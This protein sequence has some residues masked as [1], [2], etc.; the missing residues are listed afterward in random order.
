MNHEAKAF[1]LIDGYTYGGNDA[2]DLATFWFAGR[3]IERSKRSKAV[4]EF[5]VR[6]LTRPLREMYERN[7]IS[8]RQKLLSN[9]EIEVLNWLKEGK[10]T[11]DISSILKISERT[12]KFHIGNIMKKLDAINRTHAVA[13]ALR[14]GLIDPF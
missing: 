3:Y 13:I 14:D 2:E 9:R 1:G 5:V 7:R 6:A 11:W 12:V 10:S 8:D 4:I